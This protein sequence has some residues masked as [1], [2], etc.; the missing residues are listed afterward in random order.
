MRI[1][2][3]ILLLGL[4]SFPV[5]LSQAQG[6]LW[7][8]VHEEVKHATPGPPKPSLGEEITQKKAQNLEALEALRRSIAASPLESQ[9]ADSPQL[10]EEDLR[11]EF[12]GISEQILETLQEQNELEKAA[13]SVDESRERW[14]SRKETDGKASFFQLDD[15][16]TERLLQRG[17]VANLGRGIES[18][19][20]LL[21]E[22]RKDHDEKER[23]RRKAKEIWDLNRDPAAA[24]ALKF[25]WELA[26]L[27]SQN[28]EARIQFLQSDLKNLTREKEVADL[29]LGLFDE[30]IRW[31]SQN[32]KFT[33]SELQ[34]KLKQLAAEEAQLNRAL[35]SLRGQLS[36]LQKT[37]GSET[38]P[39]APISGEESG[40]LGGV[41]RSLEKKHLQT[42]VKII[43]SRLDRLQETAE[44]WQRRFQA[45][46]KKPA[47]SQLTEWSEHNQEV[48]GQIGRMESAVYA[49]LGELRKEVNK[50]QEQISLLSPGNEENKKFL[51]AEKDLIEKILF[52]YQESLSSLYRDR[53]IFEKFQSEI[54]P[55]IAAGGFGESLA[56]L[57][58]KIQWVWNYELT[59]IDDKPIT[60]KKLV[61]VLI[62]LLLGIQV[63]RRTS[64]LLGDKIFPR[65]G[66]DPGVAA[67][68]STLLFYLLLFLVSILVLY[69]VNV[70]LTMFTV[71]GGALAIGV[72][73]GS[74]YVVRNFISGLILLMERPIKVG[75]MV[76]L[77]DTTGVVERIGPRSTVLRSFSN[78][79]V[80]VPNSDFLEKKVINWTLSDDLARVSVSVG[81]SYGSATRD[82]AQL[83]QKAVEDHGKIL[84]TPEP[85]VL[86][87]DFG[88]N[89]LK[90][91]VHFWIRMRTM[92]D[93]KRLESD[94]RFRIE[95][96]FHEAGVVIA[97]PQRDIRLEASKPL[98]VQIME[99]ET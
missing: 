12:D 87:S 43:V 60:V 98:Q 82:V 14:R 80:I 86:F 89:A 11:E 78:M 49:R 36:A 61:L 29:Q 53:Q 20:K 44:L 1:L 7:G 35:D 81:V 56:K 76:Q 75:D 3:T 71:L 50:V 96:L 73:F 22:A 47:I 13:Q 92:L 74:Q 77:D 18:G 45:F 25:E 32:V 26:E 23:E 30:K 34:E 67:G 4:F 24:D 99:K 41:V 97:F 21:E 28:A 37:A 68:L 17:R 91:E 48:L 51:F 8:V 57:W 38:I 55:K 16:T 46:N 5:P 10:R 58:R 54:E 88:D 9:E 64:H 15:L 39:S 19:Q 52:V 65:L 69:I 40:S 62:L 33:P 90:F 94:V 59:S 72:G 70:P 95:S 66:L 31:L 42:R 6:P 83:L 27:R 79:Q 93:R 85:V 63:S 84:K 2:S